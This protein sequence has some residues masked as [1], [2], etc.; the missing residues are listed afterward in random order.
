VKQI[1]NRPKFES[2]LLLDPQE[3]FLPLPY[4]SIYTIVE[5]GHLLGK[6]EVRLRWALKGMI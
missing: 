4:I 1:P 3:P 5:V 2:A 6:E